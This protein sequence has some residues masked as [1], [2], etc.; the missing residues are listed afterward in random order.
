MTSTIKNNKSLSVAIAF[1]LTGIFLYLAVRGVNW[2]EVA[3]MIRSARWEKLAVGCLWAS[4]A[5]LF[6]SIRWRILL[7]SERTI[8][9]TLVFW[10]TAVGYLG[11]HFLPARVGELMRTAAIG[12]RTGLSKAY[13]LATAITE[14]LLDA[15]ILVLISSAA[16]LTMSGL[17]SWTLRSAQVMAV[18][19]SAGIAAIF[20]LPRLEKRL[21]T[22]LD[23][24]PM[25]SGLRTRLRALLSHFMLGMRVFHH[26]GR[27]VRFLAFTGLIWAIDGFTALAVSEALDLPLQFN[28]MLLLV[29]ALGLASAVPSTPGF[30]GVYQF[31]AVSVLGPFGISR[32]SSLAFILLFQ[33]VVSGCVLVW[34]LAGLWQLRS[35]GARLSVTPVSNAAAFSEATSTGSR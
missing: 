18:I 34:G 19:S 24:L 12:W 28:H 25:A 1:L 17:P 9:G 10:A 31:V 16:L 30:V 2:N 5:I 14:R 4:A 8:S 35:S 6:R 13:V 22:G 29:A 27:A 33:A 32:D 26:T 3:D 21:Q 20:A 15:G 23:L 7:E 11:N